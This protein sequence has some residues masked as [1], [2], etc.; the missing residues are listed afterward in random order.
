MHNIQIAVL[1]SF[2]LF[3]F[4]AG[5]L[6]ISIIWVKNADDSI[7]E[8]D[9]TNFKIRHAV[10]FNSHSTVNVHILSTSIQISI[11]RTFVMI[12]W[13]KGNLMKFRFF[14]RNKNLRFMVNEINNHKVNKTI[15]IIQIG[16][17]MGIKEATKV[18]M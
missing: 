3:S 18:A 10:L 9:C 6:T 14:S 2:I 4:L 5:Y 12:I 13:L 17:N 15:F 11:T 8:E 1:I 7:K 16:L